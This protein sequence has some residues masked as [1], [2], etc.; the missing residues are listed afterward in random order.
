VLEERS[1]LSTV[2]VK[3]LGE[4]ECESE[5]P[6]EVLLFHHTNLAT[7][8]WLLG[9]AHSDGRLG[10]RF[11]VIFTSLYVSALHIVDNDLHVVEALCL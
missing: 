10:L 11:I 8:W 6:I 5:N 1:D 7:S 4:K 2:T 9:L 3:N